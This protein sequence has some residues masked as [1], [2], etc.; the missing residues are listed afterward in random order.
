L[1]P[2]A[3]GLMLQASSRP[4]SS[5]LSEQLGKIETLMERCSAPTMLQ[6]SSRPMSSTL[7]EQLGKIET[8][9]ER[10]SAPTQRLQ[11]AI[12]V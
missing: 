4:M 10:C 9:M 11:S 12:S 7:S 8:L 3:G 1:L 5:T 2:D 6:A